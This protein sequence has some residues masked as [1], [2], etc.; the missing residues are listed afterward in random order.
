MEIG[1]TF[2]IKIFLPSSLSAKEIR[3]G[4]GEGGERYVALICTD[5]KEKERGRERK[6]SQIGIF[7][8][9]LR[10]SLSYPS[11]LPR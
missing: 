2:A 8:L 7:Y 11:S 5:Q 3:R 10:L 1:K 9:R 6:G 4:R